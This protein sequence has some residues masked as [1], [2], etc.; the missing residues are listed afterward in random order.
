MNEEDELNDL[1]EW[2]MLGPC[3]SCGAM[4][5]QFQKAPYAGHKEDCKLVDEWTLS[6]CASCKNLVDKLKKAPYPGHKEDCAVVNGWDYGTRIVIKLR[7][8]AQRIISILNDNDIDWYY[9]SQD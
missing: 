6:P 7:D 2:Q 8:D 4:V 3:V 9:Q 1:L 5:P